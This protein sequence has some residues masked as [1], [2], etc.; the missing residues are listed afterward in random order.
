MTVAIHSLAAAALKTESWCL[1][2][3]EPWAALG[4]RGANEVS[5]RCS[6][7]DINLR[8]VAPLLVQGPQTCPQSALLLRLRRSAPL[9]ALQLR[10]TRSPQA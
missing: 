5:S 6:E 2:D 3:M 7:T 9:L 4:W 8:R 1:T 10:S